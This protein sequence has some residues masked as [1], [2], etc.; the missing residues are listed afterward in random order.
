[1]KQTLSQIFWEGRSNLRRSNNIILCILYYIEILIIKLYTLYAL[2]VYT[3]HSTLYTLHLVPTYI[4]INMNAL[5]FKSVGWIKF[6]DLRLSY[7]IYKVK[8]VFFLFAPLF[9]CCNGSKTISITTKT[10]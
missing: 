1:M 3:L 7:G 6:L 9:C 8:K 5:T 4:Y 10:S 2:Y